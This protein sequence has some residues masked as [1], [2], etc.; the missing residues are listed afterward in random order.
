M[1]NIQKLI[2]GLMNSDNKEAYECLKK[3]ENE[4]YQSHVVY[5]Y[6]DLF[7]DM[8]ENVNSYIRTRGIILIAANAQWD[9]DYKIDE[10]IDKY[11][12]HITDDKPITARQCIKVLPIVAKYKPEL[13]EDILKAL[14]GA[15]PEIYKESMQWLVVK[16]IQKCL[17]DIENL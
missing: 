9:N 10:I 17:K 13:K 6:F 7:V 3:L 14:H 1:D 2:D 8:L 12:L 16:D 5:P 4:S 15:N 11:L